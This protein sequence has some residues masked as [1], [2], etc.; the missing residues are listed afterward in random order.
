[1]FNLITLVDMDLYKTGTPNYLVT[2]VLLTPPCSMLIES[3]MVRPS[4]PI[5]FSDLVCT[6][7][8]LQPKHETVTSINMLYHVT[9]M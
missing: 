9:N 5:D 3:S 6:V 2:S 4:F 1:M 7:Q 8:Y